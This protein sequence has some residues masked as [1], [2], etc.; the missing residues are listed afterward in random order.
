MNT[1]QQSAHAAFGVFELNVFVDESV[2]LEIVGVASTSV[3]SALW[4]VFPLFQ[5]VWDYRCR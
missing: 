5:Q 4:R 3:Y 1:D 2:V